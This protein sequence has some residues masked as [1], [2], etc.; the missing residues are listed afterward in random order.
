MLFKTGGTMGTQNPL[1]GFSYMGAF[2]RLSLRRPTFIFPLKA[3]NLCHTFPRSCGSTQGGL[4]PQD[5]SLGKTRERICGNPNF[6]G[7]VG[8]AAVKKPKKSLFSQ[9]IA[10]ANGVILDEQNHHP[11]NVAIFFN[12]LFAVFLSTSPYCLVHSGITPGA[13]SL[14]L[15]GS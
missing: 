11:I 13:L 4:F 12:P 2:P 10:T 14:S 7:S 6:L 8:L 15:R 9:I 1:L 3:T 5:F